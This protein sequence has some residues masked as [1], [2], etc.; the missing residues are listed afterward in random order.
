MAVL[1]VSRWDSPE[2][3][4]GKRKVVFTA[5]WHWKVSSSTNST[6]EVDGPIA[7]S[8]FQKRE[9]ALVIPNAG[10]YMTRSTPPC[11]VNANKRAGTPELVWT[12]P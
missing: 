10:K 11:T 5:L 8:V 7:F 3:K 1:E 12:P 6:K 4:S 9:R 2:M